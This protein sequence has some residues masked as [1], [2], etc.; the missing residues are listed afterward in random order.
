MTPQIVVLAR[1]KNHDRSATRSFLDSGVAGAISCSVTHSAVCPLDVVKTKM[2]TDVTLAGKSTVAA[3]SEVVRKSGIR[4]LLQ[5]LTATASGYFLQ[6][7]CKFGFYDLIKSKSLQVIDNEQVSRKFRFPI[8]IG[9]SAVAEV[10]AS[11]ALCPLEVTRIYMVMNPRLQ[12]GMFNAMREIMTLQGIGGFFNGLPLIMVRQ[13][14]YT[15]AK[16]AGYDIIS[17][18]MRKIVTAM[19]NMNNE[20]SELQKATIQLSSGVIAGILAATISQPADVLLSRMCGASCKHS[21]CV[22][23]DGPIALFLALRQMGFKEC[24][25]GLQPRAV[26]IGTLTAMQFFLYERTKAIVADFEFD[27]ALIQSRSLLRKA[28]NINYGIFLKSPETQLSST[29]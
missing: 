12:S 5:G 18:H 7:F 29:S 15:C 21:Q 16:L 24:F 10:I 28:I 3:F 1:K 22:I 17:D 9:S 23:V 8:L 27:D 25:T 13:I 4:V 2:Q 11:V 20:L 19:N 14:P 6:G 26:M